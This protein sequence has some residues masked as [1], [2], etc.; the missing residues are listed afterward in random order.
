[1]SELRH[2]PEKFL[3]THPPGLGARLM[4]GLLLS[5]GLVH[6]FAKTGVAQ[7]GSAGSRGPFSQPTGQRAGGG[8]DDPGNGD[9]GE[10]ARRMRAL[11]TMRQKALVS[12]TDKLLK[13]ANELNAEISANPEALTPDQLRKL[14]TIEKLAHSVKEK[15]STPVAGNPMYQ[16]PPL[17]PMM[18]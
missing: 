3:K 12:D 2:V 13:L 16:P 10:A 8:L 5:V 9:P 15:M 17:P 6:V 18:R 7:M 14:A 11:N 1:M 4:L